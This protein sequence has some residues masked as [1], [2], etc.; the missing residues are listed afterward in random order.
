MTQTMRCESNHT[1]LYWILDIFSAS[2]E[3]WAKLQCTV[4]TLTVQNFWTM[5]T[6]YTVKR[7][8]SFP[9]SAKWQCMTGYNTD[10]VETSVPHTELHLSILMKVWD[11]WHSWWF[12]C[13]MGTLKYFVGLVWWRNVFMAD[14]QCLLQTIQKSLNTDLI[15]SLFLF[16]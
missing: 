6:F 3:C 4:C 10:H 9:V 5:D 7:P 11:L 14:N 16:Y 13:S 1:L 12:N 8:P 2:F 15:M